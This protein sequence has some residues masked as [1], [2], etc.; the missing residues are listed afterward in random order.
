LAAGGQAASR[1]QVTVGGKRVRVVDVH[2]HWDMPLGDVVKGTPYEKDRAT[3]AGLDD[4]LPMMDKIGVDTEA[5]SVNDFWWWEIKDEG[6]PRRSAR[7]TTR[8]SRRGTSAI[9]IA[10]SAWPRFRCS[11]RRLRRTS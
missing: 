9:P 3:G 11:F 10:S 8:R 7:N 1:L 5:I 4:R 6:S 2:S